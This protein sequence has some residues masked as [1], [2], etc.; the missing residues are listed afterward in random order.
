MRAFPSA[1]RH[2]RPCRWLLPARVGPG[3]LLWA[4]VLLLAPGR[5]PTAWAQEP[6]A[7]PADPWARAEKI[8]NQAMDLEADDRPEEAVGLFL[9]V[10]KEFPDAPMAAD[11]LWWV[12]RYYRRL[13]REGD[14]RKAATLRTLYERF[15][16]DYADSPRLP[17]VYY[18]LGRLL[19]EEGRYRQALARF[20][21][22]AKRFPSF[23][24][25]GRV[26]YL[27]A[28]CYLK[29][30]KFAKAR[31]LFAAFSQSREPQTR[32]RGLAG[33]GQLALLRKDYPTALAKLRRAF[34]VSPTFHR[35][36][37]EAEC[38]RDLGLALLKTGNEN[39]GRRQVMRYLN[40]LGEAPDRLDLLLEIAESFHRQGRY[41]A[42]Q[43]LYR[44]VIEDGEPHQRPVI[45]AR[46]RRAMFLDDPASPLSKWDR[47][48]ELKD[49]AGDRPY[50]R[51]LE[52]EFSGPLA[53]EARRGLFRRYQARGDFGAAFDLVRTYLRQY[54]PATAT[55]ADK[56]AADAMLLFV[57]EHL[58][59][60][61]KD[62]E[63]Y[64]FYQEFAQ[65]VAAYPKGRLLYLIGQALERLRLYDQ[66]AVVYFR[67]LRL[68]L[69]P[70]DK[71]DLYYR[72]ARVYLANRDYAAA[73]RLLS[74]L[75]KVY[76]G[77][78]QAGEIA[79]YS[80]R[81]AEAKGDMRAAA[82]HYEEAQRIVTFAG[83]RQEYAERYL[84]ALAAVKG[85]EA[86]LAA[87]ERYQ[88]GQWLAPA[89]LQEWYL[90]LGEAMLADGEK[91]GAETALGRAL[92]KELPADG[93]VAQRVHFDLGRLL[94]SRGQKQEGV[95]HLQA[96]AKG[97]DRRT[98]KLA[99]EILAQGK[100]EQQIQGLDVPAK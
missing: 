55:A 2:A 59:A 54:D 45:I 89:R 35:N 1:A 61:G 68:P 95:A 66:A 97:P 22:L 25:I 49:P 91:S 12:I 17:E 4:A 94:L 7:T 31:E 71:I 30:H 75:R 14:T 76:A 48:G 80:G 98:A 11:S 39:E 33:L 67:A 82:R 21:I 34:R 47:R 13:V 20:R 43:A 3:L 99:E 81:L 92:A 69:S 73:D 18:D 79:Y 83:K 28:M 26:R 70:E 6:P 40:I 53:Q 60:A 96:A 100:L 74:Y 16:I 84:A 56:A 5:G 77:K 8:W 57:V 44:R 51:L 78:K 65:A 88:K 41:R 90:Q 64:A 42:A 93:A 85:Y 63:I 86:M 58:L 23:G 32:A 10:Y 9:R 72:R 62:K 87:L 52:L 29:L 15:I 24:R 37:P 50:L 36:N 46:F 19:Y 27:E 38:V